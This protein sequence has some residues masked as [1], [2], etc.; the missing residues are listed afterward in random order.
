MLFFV[1]Q[2]VSFKILTEDRMDYKSSDFIPIKPLV[3]RV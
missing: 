2:S 1:R 3:A